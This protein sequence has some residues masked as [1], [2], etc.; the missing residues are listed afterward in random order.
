MYSYSLKDMK[1]EDIVAISFTLCSCLMGVGSS[2]IFQSINNS[3]DYGYL[4]I[5]RALVPLCLKI[6]LHILDLFDHKINLGKVEETDDLSGFSTWKILTLL[7]SATFFEAIWMISLYQSLTS[8]KL[9][10][11]QAIIQ[12]SPV[13]VIVIGMCCLGD[14]ITCSR[15]LALL[16]L[17]I[18]IIICAL[19]DDIKNTSKVILFLSLLFFS[20]A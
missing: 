17:I 5:F 13:I 19:P 16:L 9:G 1:R 2:Y 18:G 7:S 6:F 12:G 10:I 4:L 11:V 15:L 3:I 20:R 14:K 8:E